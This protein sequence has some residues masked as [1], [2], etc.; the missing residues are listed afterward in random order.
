M[1]KIP[2]KNYFILLALYILA[3]IV[4]FA[5]ASF[6]NN[7]LKQTSSIYKY[8]NRLKKEEVKQY[9]DENPSVIV[10]IAD[11][12]DLTKEDEENALKEKIIE[13]NL[14]SNF[15]YIDK[16][17]FDD[18]LLKLFNEEYNANIS[19]D[20]IPTI[21]IYSEGRAIKVYYSIDLAAIDN[22][23]FGDIK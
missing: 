15:V 23:D 16:R 11:K 12:F 18:K 9:L 19:M 1:R 22:L 13:F 8:A 7:V 3:I 2:T 5:G 17:Q 21:I 10:Y 20:L 6:Y 14:Y 4:T